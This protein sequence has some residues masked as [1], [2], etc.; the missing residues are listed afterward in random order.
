MENSHGL[1]KVVTDWYASGQG[2]GQTW[3]N[4]KHSC[5]VDPV[6]THSGLADCIH[7]ACEGLQCPVEM[8]VAVQPAHQQVMPFVCI[9]AEAEDL[10]QNHIQGPCG[11][12]TVDPAK[13]AAS[14][15]QTVRCKFKQP[16]A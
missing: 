8:D 7:S 6:K 9:C 2:M 15:G 4:T 13:S 12:T 1:N 5:S 3:T 14:A 11:V 16:H 10:A